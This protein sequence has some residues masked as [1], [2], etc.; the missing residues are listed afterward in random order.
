MSLAS[1]TSDRRGSR[2]RWPRWLPA[3][4]PS[5]MA[6]GF[7]VATLLAVT[8]LALFSRGE[9]GAVIALQLTARWSFLLFWP[10]YAGS[11]MA[12]LFGRRFDG[13]ARRS[14]DFGL[15]YASAQIVHVS[16][17]LWI[18]YLVAGRNSGMY[19]FWV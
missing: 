2:D 10:A 5:W 18:V 17:V 3:T 6:V 11:A 4:T 16:L 12:K 9:R 14:R 1:E 7:V 8:V 15:A 13:L 19:F